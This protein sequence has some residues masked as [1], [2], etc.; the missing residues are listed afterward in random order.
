MKNLIE[1]ISYII[2]IIKGIFIKYGFLILGVCVG[3][4]ILIP[5]IKNEPHTIIPKIILTFVCFIVLYFIFAF[6][7]SIFEWFQERRNK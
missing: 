6:I 1:T 5:I 4:G 7:C 2:G 3:N